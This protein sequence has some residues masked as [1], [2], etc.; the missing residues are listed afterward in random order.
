MLDIVHILFF[1][2]RINLH[3]ATAIAAI[4]FHFSLYCMP[5]TYMI[6]N[7]LNKEIILKY[8][9]KLLMRRKNIIIFILWPYGREKFPMS[10][11]VLFSAIGKIQILCNMLILLSQMS[12]NITRAICYSLLH[13]RLVIHYMD[14]FLS[15]KRQ[16]LFFFFNITDEGCPSAHHNLKTKTNKQKLQN[17]VLVL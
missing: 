14:A 11:I 5:N 9:C 3:L 6:K 1:F 12:Y 8:F 10:F 15:L 16:Y 7:W 13:L 17:E 4:L 2:S